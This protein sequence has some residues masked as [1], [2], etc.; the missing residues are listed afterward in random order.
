MIRFGDSFESQ[1]LLLIT[2]TS[3][4]WEGHICHEVHLG[5]SKASSG[6]GL[7]L[8]VNTPLIRC[9][10]SDLT[11]HVDV[12]PVARPGDYTQFWDESAPPTY[13]KVKCLY[14]MSD[15]STPTHQVHTMLILLGVVPSQVLCGHLQTTIA[16]TFLSVTPTQHYTR[17]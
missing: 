1:S 17:I 4:H 3:V 16:P 11:R 2:S 14:T 9:V 7:S 10:N 8:M 15:I 13:T 5:N 6:G 12:C